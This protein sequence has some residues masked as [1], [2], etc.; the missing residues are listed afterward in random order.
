MSRCA[1]TFVAVKAPVRPLVEEFLSPLLFGLTET[2]SKAT[3]VEVGIGVLWAATVTRPN[4]TTS[5]QE[6]RA[7]F[8]CDSLDGP[9]AI[10]LN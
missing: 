6:K 10:W 5:P 1:V 2:T 7:G 4:V 3:S 8:M 9:T